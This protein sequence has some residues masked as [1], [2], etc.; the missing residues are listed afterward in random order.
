MFFTI[1]S[2][3]LSMTL[4]IF[5][6]IKLS[7]THS[8]Q[9]EICPAN[10]FLKGD[11]GHLT[12]HGDSFFDA[13]DMSDSKVVDGVK[14]EVLLFDWDE[15]LRDISPTLEKCNEVGGNPF[16]NSSRKSIKSCSRTKTYS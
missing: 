6:F 3:S 16:C 8:E 7:L 13:K 14:E 11:T 4:I 12:Y 5:L 9:I 15:L 10:L 1:Q 2:F